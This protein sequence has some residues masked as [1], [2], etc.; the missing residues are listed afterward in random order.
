MDAEGSR[1]NR[2][3]QAFE[4]KCNHD[5]AVKLSNRWMEGWQCF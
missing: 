5:G 2:R 1:Q 4:I 3:K